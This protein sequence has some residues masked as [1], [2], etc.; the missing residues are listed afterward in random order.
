MGNVE[1]DQMKRVLMFVFGTLEDFPP[2]MNGVIGLAQSGVRVKI[3]AI[4]S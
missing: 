4:S 2:V 3:I 1:V